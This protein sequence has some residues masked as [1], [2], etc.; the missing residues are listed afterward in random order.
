VYDARRQLGTIDLAVRGGAGEGG[1]DRWRGLALIE[2]MDGSIGVVDGHAG[3]REQFCGG[4]FAH[5]DRTGQ[6]ENPH[7]RPAL[8]IVQSLMAF[9]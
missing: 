5:S 9:D 8:C 7:Q 3:L 6:S 2:L 4:G 1:L